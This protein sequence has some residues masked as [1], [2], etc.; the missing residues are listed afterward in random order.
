MLLIG[1]GGVAYAKLVGD[2]VSR[3][4]RGNAYPGAH[5]DR[6]RNTFQLAMVEAARAV[7]S[8]EVGD[9]PR[10]P[11]RGPPRKRPLRVLEIGIG[12][13]ARVATRGLYGGALD[14]LLLLS[15][16]GGADKFPSSILTGVE[17]TG[18]DIKVPKAEILDYARE[19]LSHPNGCILPS[20]RTTLDVVQGNIVAVSYTHLTLPTILLV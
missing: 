7:Q 3:I 1:T 14:E 2:A 10:N 4:A 15:S 20:F 11:D 17:I 6:V 19:Q 8:R 18:I 12:S 9:S 16:G 13:E 5:E